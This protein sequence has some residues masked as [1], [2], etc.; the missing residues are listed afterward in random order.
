MHILLSVC[1]EKVKERA[2]R[3]KEDLKKGVGGER[4]REG[5]GQMKKRR[6]DEEKKGA[7]FVI[8]VIIGVVQSNEI[9]KSDNGKL[10]NFFSFYRNLEKEIAFRL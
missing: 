9:I 3:E 10:F 6:Q 5:K 8:N 1:A 2:D 7:G 4:E